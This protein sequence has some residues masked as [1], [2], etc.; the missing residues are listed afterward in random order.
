MKARGK[1]GEFVQERKPADVFEIMEPLEP[2]M[3]SESVAEF[4][5]SRRSAYEVVNGLVDDGGI[6]KKEPQAYYRDW[7]ECLPGY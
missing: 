6:H 1:G 4:E 7:D 2:Y 5:W 3:T